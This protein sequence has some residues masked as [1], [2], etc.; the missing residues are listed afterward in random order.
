MVVRRPGPAAHYGYPE[1]IGD[2]KKDMAQLIEASPVAQAARIKAPLLLAYGAED[3]RVPKDHGRRLR[4]AMT[5]AGNPP[6]Y[7]EYENEG[8]GW[9]QMTTRLDFA[10]RVENFLGKH[11]QS[12]AP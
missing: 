3:E 11:L 9:Q 1:L 10:K 8:H 2:P 7:G 5:K 12:P 4:D 6:D